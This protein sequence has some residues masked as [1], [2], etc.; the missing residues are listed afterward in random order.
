M[1][2]IVL[3]LTCWTK[4]LKNRWPLVNECM[5]LNGQTTRQYRLVYGK[6]IPSSS[7]LCC[8]FHLLPAIPDGCSLHLFSKSSLLKHMPVTYH[9][10]PS[11]SHKFFL[12]RRVLFT[13]W[14]PILSLIPQ[15]VQ[16]SYIFLLFSLSKRTTGQLFSFL[17]TLS[18]H[19]SVH[20]YSSLKE[21][22][23]EEL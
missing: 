16:A 22:A 21:S 14:L 13:A 20:V 5:W 10:S 9:A 11:K 19:W 15:R 18:G 7:V 1:I 4:E 6:L 8:W 17:Q 2:F 23:E 3:L 12:C